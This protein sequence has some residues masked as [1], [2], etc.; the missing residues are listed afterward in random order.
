MDDDFEDYDIGVLTA[1]NEKR[2]E[3]GED[4]DAEASNKKFHYLSFVDRYF[5]KYY[6]L[7]V[8]H[9]RN[10][11]LVLF[12]SN[13]VC[14]CSIAPSHPVL[15]KDKYKIEKIEFIQKVSLNMKGKHKT[16]AKNLNYMQ[17]YC[18]LICSNIVNDPV[19]EETFLIYS[20]LNAKLIEI[21]E[22]IV[23]DPKLVQDKPQGDGFI[24]I[25]YPKIDNLNEQLKELI[26]HEEYER[27]LLERS[28]S[29]NVNES[30]DKTNTENQDIQANVKVIAKSDE[31][32]ENLNTN[33]S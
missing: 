32:S 18:K 14:V 31:I 20:C 28:S 26:S 21:N 8:K 16:N 10:D 29:S 5:R 9:Y 6:K 27:A 12:H 17:P 3:I 13:R 19:T 22:N 24:A 2:K 33:S 11:H 4:D 25:L 1:I 7:D 30:A 23:S 15:D